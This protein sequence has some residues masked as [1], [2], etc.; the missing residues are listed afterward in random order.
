[1]A[2]VSVGDGRLRLRWGRWE[3]IG[4]FRGDVELPVSAIHAV[5]TVP[6][7]YAE[8]HGMRMPGG[9]WPGRLAVGTWRRRG[10]RDIVAV[11]GR[12]PK[13]VVI[14]F[15]P[16]TGIDRWIVSTDDPDALAATIRAARA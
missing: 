11:H 9:A 10:R 2:E 4:A 3:R 6:D 16:G 7:A 8:I 14:E 13:G 5:R 1:M 15:E 12:T